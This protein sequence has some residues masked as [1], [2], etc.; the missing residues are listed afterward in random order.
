MFQLKILLNL[1]TSYRARLAYNYRSLINGHA[2][3]VARTQGRRSAPSRGTLRV[4]SRR[5]DDQKPCFC[6]NRRFWDDQ[7]SS[8][9]RSADGLLR[10]SCALLVS[11]ANDGAFA[12]Y[13]A[14][15]QPVEAKPARADW[16]CY[17]ACEAGKASLRQLNEALRSEHRKMR[18]AAMQ[19]APCALRGVRMAVIPSGGN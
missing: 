13:L 1:T 17:A 7:R 14:A 10:R 15:M 6:Q 8:S 5:F 2:Q 16:D 3:S 4:P 9:V 19:P 11:R 18:L 12:L